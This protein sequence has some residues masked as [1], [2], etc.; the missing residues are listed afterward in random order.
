MSGKG[1]GVGGRSGSI[2]GVHGNNCESTL[3]V[4]GECGGIAG[5][6]L[7]VDLKRWAV[8]DQV[9]SVTEIEQL[10]NTRFSPEAVVAAGRVDWVEPV[11]IAVFDSDPMPS[12][13]G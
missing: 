11:I 6:L 8:R 2:H 7:W 3:L 5:N 4:Y 9:P 13:G 1:I 12:W 10:A